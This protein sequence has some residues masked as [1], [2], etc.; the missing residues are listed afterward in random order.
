MNKSLEDLPWGSM[1]EWKVLFHQVTYLKSFGLNGRRVMLVCF[2][3]IVKH[4]NLSNLNIT[5]NNQEKIGIW[6]INIMSYVFKR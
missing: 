5:F 2:I 3:S 1:W 4:S 6:G